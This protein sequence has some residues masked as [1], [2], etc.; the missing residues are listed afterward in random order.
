MKTL[1]R[2]SSRALLRCT[3][4]K[5]NSCE[6]QQDCVNGFLTVKTVASIGGE[7]SFVDQVLLSVMTSP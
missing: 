3:R 2:K 4:D 7:Y 6:V 1:D 5:G